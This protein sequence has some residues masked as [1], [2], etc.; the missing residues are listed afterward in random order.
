MARA[1]SAGV[2]V[3]GRPVLLSA[4][5]RPAIAVEVNAV[6]LETTISAG[7]AQAEAV[8]ALVE[9]DG[10][11]I[12]WCEPVALDSLRSLE[13]L[14]Y[15]RGRHSVEIVRSHPS[16]LAELQVGTWFHERARARLAR[17][18][19]R[20]LPWLATFARVVVAR[21][22]TAAVAV[23]AWF[24]SG[25]RQAATRSEWRRIARSGYSVLCY[26]RLAGRGDWD[27]VAPGSLAR[28]LRLL[29]RLGF[30][31]L[32]ADDVLAFARDPT[33]VLGRRRFLVTADDGYDD[34]LEVLRDQR[35]LRP[36]A[37][38][39][40]GFASRT[41]RAPWAV[42]ERGA[43]FADWH[44]VRK[45][46]AE[47]IDIGFHTL[48][49]PHLVSCDDDELEQELVDAQRLFAQEHV[50]TR[51]IIA[52]PHGEADRRVR[53]RARRAG[54]A[55]GYTIEPGVNGA[56]TDPLRL[57]RVMVTSGDGPLAVAW[58]ALT[59]ESPPGALAWF[60]RRVGRLGRRTR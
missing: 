45:A 23:D 21:P 6:D 40:A 7:V 20:R 3:G 26:H 30:V 60:R 39:V 27:D 46:E 2:T 58:M 28:Q 47:G 37:F 25:V 36:L 54:Y 15:E 59:G 4:P 53:A 56:G 43:S 8:V 5:G 48:T 38:V 41:A 57:R 51:P 29:R 49:H 17:R 22:A 18:L 24:W 34:A 42:E 12:E 50:V 1:R 14:S 32:S 16:L 10:G 55:L 52:Y 19:V 33:A 31:S 13:R 35:G 44:S 11:E 9:R